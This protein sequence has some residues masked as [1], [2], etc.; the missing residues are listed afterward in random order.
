MLMGKRKNKTWLFGTGALLVALWTWCD[1]AE[2]RAGRG[3]S[4]GSRGSRS[5]SA[6]SRSSTPDSGGSFNDRTNPSSS[7][8]QR[9][10]TQTSPFGGGGLMRGIGAGLLGG[11]VGSMLF[12]SLGFAGHGAAGTGW[13]GPGFFDLLLL[14]GLG[15]L[16][17]RWFSQRSMTPASASGP[18]WSS[19]QR[20]RE[21]SSEERFPS[22]GPVIN[23]PPAQ[24][25]D[26]DRGIEQIRVLDH[27][28]DAQRFCDQTMDLFF[29]LQAAWSTRD[30]TPLRQSLTEEVLA[31][32][33]TDVDRL[34]REGL[35]N[36]VENIA[37][38]TCEIAEA[39]QESGQDFVTA[40]F[41]ANCLDYDAKEATG[42]VVRGSK[43][44]PTKFEE[45][46]TFTRPAGNG[47]WRLSAIT[48]A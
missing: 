11:F 9:P 26:L 44:E 18:S 29:R 42:E 40:Y 36:R 45:F 34:K 12:S 41:Y 47:A 3:G 27:N 35:V 10:N 37:V 38:R 28:F 1:F 19:G 15:Y 8:A 13:G 32:L 21:W 22:Q 23:L 7:F 14:A 31:Q 2:A 5:D 46:W 4:F 16:A 33:Q 24:I 48:Q 17:Y 43:T 6:P 20:A 39:W 30:L 25:R